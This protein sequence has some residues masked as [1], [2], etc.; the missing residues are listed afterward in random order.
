MPP[1]TPPSTPP[2]PTDDATAQTGPRPPA[3]LALVAGIGLEVLALAAGAVLVL[4]ELVA[5]RSMSLGVSL[6]LVVFALGVAALLAACVRGLL[7]GRRWARSPVA[8][9]QILQGVVAVSSIQVGATPWALV[10]LAL[11]VVVLV[12]LMLRP[13]VEST[14]RDARPSA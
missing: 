10:A 13:V 5:G 1:R 9:W 2:G 3:L 12:L 6:F 4:V 14:T 11:A 8:T 7:Q